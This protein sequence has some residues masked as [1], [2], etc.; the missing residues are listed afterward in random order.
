MRV[1]AAS[2]WKGHAAS[3]DGQ[4]SSPDSSTCGRYASGFAT[5]FG[6]TI[7]LSWSITFGFTIGSSFLHGTAKPCSACTSRHLGS[8]ICVPGLSIRKSCSYLQGEA[9]EFETRST[10]FR[11]IHGKKRLDWTL[12]GNCSN[13]LLAFLILNGLLIII[14]LLRL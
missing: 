14:V 13:Y 10:D 6:F 9:I 2:F 1:P 12:V 4:A 5:A 3:E 7:G 8:Q 11:N